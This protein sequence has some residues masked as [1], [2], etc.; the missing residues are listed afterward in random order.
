MTNVHT[1]PLKGN[2]KV[3]CSVDAL[4]GLPRKKAAG[5]SH[6]GALHGNLF[7]SDQ[8]SVD[9]FVAEANSLKSMSKVSN[10]I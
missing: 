6:R 4:F 2:G 9:E 10:M 8:A 3:I 1:N 7:F 5:S